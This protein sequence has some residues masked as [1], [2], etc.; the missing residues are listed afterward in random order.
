MYNSSYENQPTTIRG[1]TQHMAGQWINKVGVE[2]ECGVH[3]DH[4]RADIAG[5]NNTTDG[6]LRDNGNHTSCR[7]FVSEAHDYPSQMEDLKL[8]LED[9]YE[10]INEINESMGLHIHVSFTKDEYYYRLAS[11]KF[12]EFF[13]NR[14]KQTSL[15]ENNP[16]LQKR[17]EGGENNVTGREADYFCR[18]VDPETIDQQLRDR[19]G[20]NQKYRRIVFFKNKYDTVEFRLFSAME[21]AE[22][23]MQ[24]VDFTTRTINAYMQNTQYT[25]QTEINVEKPAAQETQEQ[26]NSEVATTGGAFHSV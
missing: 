5:F 2:V 1:E 6:S 14:L 18:N 16:S 21:T 22:E 24:A 23:V 11:T 7:E 12:E 26:M 4:S 9:V 25:Q 19:R 8:G 10:I 20:S 3:P 15:W 17:V 13:I